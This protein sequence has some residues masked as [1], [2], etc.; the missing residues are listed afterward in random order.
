MQ[1][2]KCHNGHYYD[3]TLYSDCPYCCPANNDTDRTIPFDTQNATIPFDNQNETV[4]LNPNTNTD[5]GA[6][7]TVPLDNRSTITNNWQ[8]DEDNP[9][10][11]FFPHK[12]GF[13]P[14]VG[15]IV[16]ID[17]EEKGKDFRLQNG[18]NMIG[19]SA[20]MSIRLNSPLISRDNHAWIAYDNLNRQFLFGSGMNKNLVYVN[21]QPVIGSAVP[22]HPYDKLLMGKST[23]LFV[24]FCGQEFDW[25]Q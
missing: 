25:V 7:V 10:I 23:Y 18:N 12:E 3:S 13:N 6:S 19:R 1:M 22:L 11:A 21:N 15:W 4:P 20:S 2:N 5:S 17:G 14:V 16:C 9:T 8:D 24:P